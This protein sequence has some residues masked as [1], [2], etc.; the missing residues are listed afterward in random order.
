MT[1]AETRLPK[2]EKVYMP[3]ET[4]VECRGCG[5]VIFSGHGG[6]VRA[7]LLHELI[8]AHKAE[9]AGKRRSGVQSVEVYVTPPDGSAARTDPIDIDWP[10]G[11]RIPAREE[12]LLLDQGRFRVDTVE[13]DMKGGVPVVQLRVSRP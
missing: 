1:Y 6:T 13:W 5:G 11:W 8:D 4:A 12:I 9:C 2:A 3:V 10:A 7:E